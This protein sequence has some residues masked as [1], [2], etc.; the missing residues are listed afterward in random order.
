MIL[1]DFVRYM[2][3]YIYGGYRECL[4]PVPPTY[5]HVQSIHLFENELNR[6]DFKEHG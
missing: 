1:S 3:V 5:A 4:F 6:T 2:L